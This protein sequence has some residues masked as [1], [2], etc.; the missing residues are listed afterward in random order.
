MSKNQWVEWGGTEGCP[1]LPI[2]ARVRV[3]W[4]G[5]NVDTQNMH[6]AAALDWRGIDSY[7]V[8]PESDADRAVRENAALREERDDAAAECERLRTHVAEV[9][10]LCAS[11]GRELNAMRAERDELR[12]CVDRLCGEIH[13]QFMNHADTIAALNDGV[14]R[15]IAA[16]DLPA[17]FFARFYTTWAPKK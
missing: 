10:K 1:E 11:T 4:F 13:R 5:G 17:D 7:L 6:D 14:R 9:E 3:R 16:G 12:D 15:G 2:G 8:I